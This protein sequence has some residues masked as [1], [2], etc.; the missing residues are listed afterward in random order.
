MAGGGTSGGSTFRGLTSGG[1]GEVMM[2]D[3]SQTTRVDEP[4]PPPAAASSSSSSSS[5][6][7]AHVAGTNGATT[8]GTGT[9]P[10][11]GGGLV[12]HVKQTGPSSIFRKRTMDPA[13][14]PNGGGNLGE[15]GLRYGIFDVTE[16]YDE[17]AYYLRYLFLP[18]LPLLTLS[19][20]PFPTVTYPSSLSPSH[21]HP[22]LI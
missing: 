6:S 2:Y 10:I 3:D 9:G 18:F 12:L 22:L 7:S 11:S 21:P 8:T 17:V 13:A 14:P 19:L 1:D 15:K 4:L 5:S 20:P 16:G